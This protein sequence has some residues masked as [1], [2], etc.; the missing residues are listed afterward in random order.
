MRT[1]IVPKW[2]H[3][4]I[5]QLP[6][7][8]VIDYVKKDV[9]FT[10]DSTYELDSENQWD[11]N[12]LLGFSIGLLPKK[13][14][15][16]MWYNSVR[17]AWRYVDGTIQVSPYTYCNGEMNY[18]YIP[19]NLELEKQ[20]TFII[21]QKA[22]AKN[23]FNVYVISSSKMIHEWKVVL[24]TAITTKWGWAACLVF[25]GSKRAPKTIKVKMKNVGYV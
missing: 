5:N 3:A 14:K 13:W 25:G 9:M 7:P 1:L 15:R 21:S 20:Y 12:K 6:Y 2:F 23:A 18:D 10:K 4:C 17:V 16:P 22:H 24:P 11:W 8:F 19:V